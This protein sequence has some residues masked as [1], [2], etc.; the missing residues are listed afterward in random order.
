MTKKASVDTMREVYETLYAKRAEMEQFMDLYLFKRAGCSKEEFIDDKE[1]FIKFIKVCS[2]LHSGPQQRERTE[3]IKVDFVEKY[4]DIKI[5]EL[6]KNKKIEELQKI[7]YGTDGIGQKI[8]SFMLELIFLYSNYR[9]E[10]AAQK[11]YVPIDTHIKRIF[12]ESFGHTPPEISVS[13]SASKKFP[14]KFEDFQETL[15]EYTGGKP[16]V[17]FDYLWYIGKVYCEKTNKDGTFS[18]GYKLCKE[19]WIAKQCAFHPKWE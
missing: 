7:F 3:R 13:Y 18:R 15:N 8:G 4:S 1:Q 17:Y 9:D 6:V 10:E 19:C 5:K 12:E 16:R 2:N 14:K 11:L